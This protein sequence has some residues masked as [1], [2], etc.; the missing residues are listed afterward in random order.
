MPIPRPWLRSKLQVPTQ[1]VG[2]DCN[3]VGSL[4]SFVRDRISGYAAVG[5]Y[6]AA[7]YLASMQRTVAA[8]AVS[9]AQRVAQGGHTKS[10]PKHF[11]D[12][13]AF[14]AAQFIFLHS[15]LLAS[16]LDF[17]SLWALL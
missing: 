12:L 11:A 15:R 14:C 13:K 6:I 7:Y 3:N 16:C 17:W 9:V 10:L 2:E 8:F 4:A 5:P 1:G